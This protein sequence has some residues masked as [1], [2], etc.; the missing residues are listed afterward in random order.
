MGGNAVF[1]DTVHL[2]CPDL[3]LERYARLADQCRMKGLVVIRFRDRDIILKTSGYRSVHLVYDAEHRITVREAVDEDAD[4][5]KIIYLIK[6]LVLDKHFLVNAEIMLHPAIN[7]AFYPRVL[8]GCLYLINYLRNILLALLFPEVDIL[9]QLL[10]F[11]R[12]KIAEREV[13]KLYLQSG[14]AKTPR[15]GSV[16]I[17]SLPGL[18]PL[19]FR[20]HILKS[21]HIVSAVRQ[22]DDDH[23]DILRH[24]NEHLAEVFRLF[25]LL[26]GIPCQVSQLGNA[27][28]Q[29]GHCIAEPRPDII[30][31]DIRVFHHIMKYAGD[32]GVHVH[33]HLGQDRGDAKRMYDIGFSGLSPLVLMRVHGQLNCFFNFSQVSSGFQTLYGF[34]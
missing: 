5:E 1:G 19:L 26:A 12:L 22:L 15:Q 17:Q 33:L 27:V 25:V 4:R 29:L 34:V 21:P 24:R 32:N 28:D 30:K 14:Y 16:D 8:Y 3:Y 2:I 20:L 23:P 9:Y 11:L 7:L 13:V 31:A 18:L 6:V 10:V